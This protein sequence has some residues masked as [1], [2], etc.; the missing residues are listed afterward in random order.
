MMVKYHQQLVNFMQQIA[1]IECEGYQKQGKRNMLFSQFSKHI[2]HSLSHKGK[3]SGCINLIVF[4]DCVHIRISIVTA[5]VKIFRAAPLYNN[6]KGFNFIHSRI[7]FKVISRNLNDRFFIH[8]F[9]KYDNRKTSYEITRT[10][11]LF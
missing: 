2:T 6:L 3:G 8:I 1:V 4:R 5:K 11:Y 7:N 9:Y 10:T